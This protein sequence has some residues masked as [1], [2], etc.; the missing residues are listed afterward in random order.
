MIVTYRINVF[1]IVS[2][3]VSICMNINII[4]SKKLLE[5]ESRIDFILFL[6]EL[7]FAKAEN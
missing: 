6:N 2:G 4:V 5:K 7:V 1:I 3:P